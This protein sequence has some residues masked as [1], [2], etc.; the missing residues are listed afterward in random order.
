MN[1]LDQ[2]T[3]EPANYNKMV[4]VQ[5]TQT[6]SLTLNNHEFPNFMCLQWS[7]VFYEQMR[8]ELVW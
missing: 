5:N 2:L 4:A 3:K 8:Y 1:L 6:T 7:S